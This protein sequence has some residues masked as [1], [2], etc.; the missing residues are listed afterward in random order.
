MFIFDAIQSITA[1]KNLELNYITTQT[2]T[3]KFHFFE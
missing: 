2:I 3:N 1:K